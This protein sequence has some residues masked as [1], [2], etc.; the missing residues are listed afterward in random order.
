MKLSIIT[1]SY[2]Q[3]RFI[4]RTL[5]SVLDQGYSDLEYWVIDGGSTDET[6]D[7]LRRYEDRLMWV[8]EKDKG[9]ADAVNKGFERATGEVVGWINS[10]D[11]YP[12]GAFDAVMSAFQKNPD[13]D[14]VLGDC[15]IIDESDRLLRSRKSGPF[16]LRRLIRMGSSY[17]FQPSVFFK[18][19]LLD[20]VGG[21]DIT[22]H[23]GMDYDLWCR[24]GQV[25]KTLYLRRPL[26]NWRFQEES[27]SCSQRH[28]SLEEGRKI[29]QRYGKPSDVPWYWYYD[30]RAKLYLLAE[31]HLLGWR[32]QKATRT[33]PQP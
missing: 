11:T 19:K 32:N 27:K 12:P 31:P 29:R 21:C 8:S 26:S 1:P 20:Q 2:N 5:N 10:D 16:N 6:L 28:I 24:M 14:F 4:E 25:A 15:D 18:R 3:G 30:L 23:H 9:Q 33:L 7:I 22:F 17:V 13:V